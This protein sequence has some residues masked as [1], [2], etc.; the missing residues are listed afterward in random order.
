PEAWVDSSL[1]V[2]VSTQPL[3]EWDYG[4]LWWVKTVDYSQNGVRRTQQYFA[5][6]GDGGNLIA[7]FPGVDLAVVVTQ[8]NYSDFGTYD[9]QNRQIL[10]DYILPA[11]NDLSIGIEEGPAEMIRQDDLS[12]DVFPNPA[13]GRTTIRYSVSGTGPLVVQIWDV[14]GREVARLAELRSGSNQL[15]IETGDLPTGTYLARVGQ[16]SRAVSQPLVL[17]R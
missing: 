3:T 13:P 6:E 10:A 17:V 8:G 4:Y 12:I 5:A 15:T 7:V 11:V 9:C 16:G 14:L 1:A 2:Q